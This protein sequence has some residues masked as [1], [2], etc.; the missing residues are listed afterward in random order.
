MKFQ[1]LFPRENKKDSDQVAPLESIL[2]IV[3]LESQHIKALVGS[4]YPTAGLKQ[5]FGRQVRKLF[6]FR[7][8][9]ASILNKYIAGR[10][11]PVSYP[12]GPITARCRFIKNAYWV[13]NRIMFFFLSFF[14]SSTEYIHLKVAPIFFI[15]YVR[16]F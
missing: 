9:P 16:C 15:S 6:A 14:S 8:Y 7:A 13:I 4:S 5:W 12:D 3:F 1:S 11:R 2:G 10:Y